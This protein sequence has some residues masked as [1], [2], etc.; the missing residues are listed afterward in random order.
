MEIKTV[1]GNRGVVTAK[2]NII[3]VKTIGFEKIK[4]EDL[5]KIIALLIKNESD[6]YPKAL[7]FMGEER[8]KKALFT[9]FENRYEQEERINKA[10]ELIKSKVKPKLFIQKGFDS[11]EWFQAFCEKCGTQSYCNHCNTYVWINKKMN[12]GK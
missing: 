11:K 12:G 8:L 5:F 3:E 9:L 1:K 4:Y 2:D 10:I 7:G 6:I